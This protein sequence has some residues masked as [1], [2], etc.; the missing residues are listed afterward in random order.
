M[1]G[2]RWVWFRSLAAINCSGAEAVGDCAE[3]SDHLANNWFAHFDGQQRPFGFLTGED[4]RTTKP[5]KQLGWRQVWFYCYGEGGAVPKGSPD[6]P[7][8]KEVML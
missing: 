5:D 6:V 1:F 8:G 4:P 3:G 2:Q 7:T